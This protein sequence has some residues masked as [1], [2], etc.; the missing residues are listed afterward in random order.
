MSTSSEYR[1]EDVVNSQTLQNLGTPESRENQPDAEIVRWD[2]FL[3]VTTPG[4]SIAASMD[5]FKA[6]NMTAPQRKTLQGFY[7]EFTD[8]NERVV[9]VDKSLKQLLGD[10]AMAVT[11]ESDETYAVSVRSPQDAL[12]VI[13]E[14]ERNYA[15]D[16]EEEFWDEIDSRHALVPVMYDENGMITDT[17]LSLMDGEGIMSGDNGINAD[18]LLENEEI[19]DSA[20]NDSELKKY[21]ALD[22]EEAE[23]YVE[24]LLPPDYDEVDHWTHGQSLVIEVDGEAE[25]M[26]TLT[27][28]SE[29]RDYGEKNGIYS[30]E[31]G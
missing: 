14:Y 17:G 8:N 1:F 20:L 11:S 31:I 6:G 10:Q 23:K 22:S 4:S 7:N 5:R 25:H 15:G 2:D 21:P 16:V 28:A 27:P 3:A 19:R 24:V 26:E 30:I 13:E 12:E 9:F 29:V 18:D